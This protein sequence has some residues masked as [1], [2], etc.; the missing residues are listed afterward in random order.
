MRY[1]TRAVLVLSMVSLFADIASE[2]LYPVLPAFLD[3]IGFGVMG[4]G[5]LEGLAVLISGF[6]NA[7][8]GS[9]S[10]QI[11]RRYI[12]IRSGYLLSAIGKP[13]MGLF[14]FVGPVFAGR[15]IDRMGKGM[16]GA[17]RDAVLVGESRPEDR[18]KVFGFHRAMDT[19]GAVIG[20]ILALVYLHFYPNDIA[21][22]LVLS[23]V[24]GIV[25]VAITFFLPK[26]GAP[27]PQPGRPRPFKGIFKFWKRASPDYKRL[28][29]GLLAF[30]L[31]NSSDLLLL[32]RAGEAGVTTANVVQAYIIYNIVYALASFPLGGLADKL[33]FKPVFLAG[34]AAFACV[35]AGMA[36]ATE[37]WQVYL[38]FGLYGCF[39]AANEGIAKSWLSLFI[40]P[41]DKGTGLGLYKFSSN[42]TNFLA[43]PLMGGIW[44]LAGGE[45]A[46]LLI[47]GLAAV[48]IFAFAFLLP[49]KQLGK[50]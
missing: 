47:G 45:G 10:D 33:G 19:L 7:Y 25:S 14:P 5:L 43:S 44:L 48:Q 49:S 16:R 6:G 37:E 13:L 31:L 12:F 20:P 34:M 4:I 32:L 50:A 29:G 2:M 18:G 15:S 36:F 1:I 27:Q 9:L 42:A 40:A 26:E 22:I 3:G 28:L 38:L 17:A 46:F 35:Y 24:P 39:S 23:F 41:A 21:S 11:D 30:A 8:F